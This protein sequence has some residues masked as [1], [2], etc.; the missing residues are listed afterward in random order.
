MGVVNGQPV[1]A[2]ITNPAFINK[3]VD[4][5]MPNILAFSRTLSGATVS[6]IQAATNRLYTCTGASESTTGTVYSAPAGTITNGQSHQAALSILAGK[7]SNSTGHTHDGSAGNGNPIATSSLTGTALLQFVTQ[8]TTITGAT[9]GSTD[10]TS[11]MTGLIPSSNDTTAGVIV[12]TPYNRVMVLYGDTAKYRDLVVDSFGDNIYGRLTYS[13]GT[14][15]LT[16][17]V[18]INGVETAATLP[19]TSTLLWFYRELQNPITSD[20]PNYSPLFELFS[21]T[22]NTVNNLFGNLT[23]AG[24]GG[25]VL[26]VVGQTLTFTSPALSATAATSVATTSSVGAG[27]TSARSDHAHQGVHS[28]A[29]SGASQLYGDATLSEGANV[30]L[31]QVGQDIAISVPTSVTTVGTF[32]SQ[33]KSANAAVISGATIYFQSADAS[34]P[35]MVT[36]SSQIFAGPKTFSSSVTTPIS[37]LSGSVSGLLSMVAAATTVSYGITWPSAQ[38]SGTQFLSN[39]GSGALSWVTGA[40]GTVSTIGTIDSETKSADGAVITGADLVLQTADASFP[41]L[42]STTTQ[43]YAGQ[44][45]F[46]G[47]LKSKD[48]STVIYDASDPTIQLLVNA[49]G[50][51]GTSTTLTTSQ[52]ANRVLVTPDI[53]DTLMT[54]TTVDLC[55]NKSLE[56]AT[57]WFVDSVDNTKAIK[58]NAAGTTGTSTTLLSSQTVD[59]TITIPDFTDTLAVLAGSQTFTTKTLS[60][61]SNTFSG[62]TANA[63]PLADGSGILGAGL[64]PGAAGTFPRSNGTTWAVSAIQNSDLPERIALRAFRTTNQSIPDNT[65]TTVAFDNTDYDNSGGFNLSTGVWTCPVAGKYDIQGIA[66]FGAVATGTRVLYFRLNGATVYEIDSKQ[67][68]AIYAIRLNGSTTL[69]LALN[70]TLELMVLQD[71][72]GPLNYLSGTTVGSFC[73]TQVG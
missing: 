43:T 47:G 26:S 18:E 17:Y 6:D 12:N 68:D 16:Y 7:F 58:F 29:K 36:I 60:R 71:S 4:D 11:L 3:N 62:Y 35:G 56:D 40:T 64:A 48:S 57:C 42:V 53:S 44:K 20:S 45:D 46:S 49:A 41:G 22:V 19:A 10:V 59:R 67:G 54:K 1:S 37:S 55:K 30:T 50:T 28:I 63:L 21:R 65:L 70:D 5:S 39:D 61:A 8:G 34:F 23:F 38:A 25:T 31:T 51:T 24:V 13:T 33:A 66:K 73:I 27:T 9:G 14:W 69:N 15:T 52:T 32:D 72:T 2:E